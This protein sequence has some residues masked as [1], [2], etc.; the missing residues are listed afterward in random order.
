VQLGYAVTVQTVLI[1]V[2]PAI[3]LDCCEAVR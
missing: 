1:R 3:D 2:T